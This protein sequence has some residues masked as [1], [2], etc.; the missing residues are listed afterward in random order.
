M[1]QPVDNLHHAERVFLRRGR[2]RN[3]GEWCESQACSGCDSQEQGRE[4]LIP[5]A[6][7]AGN[8]DD[9]QLCEN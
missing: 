2:L 7:H 8:P 9:L 6:I 4:G 3:T 1:L 5:H